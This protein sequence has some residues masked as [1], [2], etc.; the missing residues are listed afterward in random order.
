MKSEG[1]VFCAFQKLADLKSRKL[2]HDSAETISDD[3]KTRKL[4]FDDMPDKLKPLAEDLWGLIEVLSE[5]DGTE[6][7]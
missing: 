7:D 1:D 2:Q 5:E 4:I 3:R 6:I